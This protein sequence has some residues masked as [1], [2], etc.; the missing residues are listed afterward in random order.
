MKS[1]YSYSLSII[2]IVLFMCSFQIRK[3]MHMYRN[4]WVIPAQQNLELKNSSKESLEVVLYNP[5]QYD[6]LKY[7]NGN[8]RVE[9]L[10]KND[11]ILT[12][13]N[14]AKEFYVINNSG[15]EGK[16]KIKILNNSGKVKAFIKKNLPKN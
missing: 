4:H 13:I 1:L 12:K 15:N 9:I 14:F 2:C 16:F 11:S 3:G 6:D 5:S 10:P 7:I 8:N